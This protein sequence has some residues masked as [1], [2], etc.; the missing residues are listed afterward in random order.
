MTSHTFRH[1]DELSSTADRI[2][3]KAH[4]VDEVMAEKYISIVLEK[5]KPRKNSGHLSIG[6]GTT[7]LPTDENE[8]VFFSSVKPGAGW[9][10]F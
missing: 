8:F 5:Y 3:V 1:A 10:F 2:G 6:E 4:L 7:K 9:I